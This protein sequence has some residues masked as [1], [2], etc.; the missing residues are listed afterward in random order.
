[1]SSDGYFD[2]DLDDAAWAQ[3]DAI[4]AAYTVSTSGTQATAAKP[5]ASTSTSVPGP[6]IS[7]PKPKPL[8]SA[9][10]EDSFYDLTFD[11]DEDDFQQLDAIEQTYAGKTRPVGPTRQTTLFGDILPDNAQTNKPSSSRQPLQLTTS[12]PRNPFGSKPKKTKIWDQTAFAQSGQR[13][14]GKGKVGGDGVE[15]EE[16][17]PEF[18]QYPAPYVSPGESY[19]RFVSADHAQ[20]FRSIDE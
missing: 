3:L 13:K 4:E 12:T 15:K 8:D 7:K 5:V 19:S 2:D 17:P 6:S 14:K 10:K 9:P 11:L 1:M 16:P 20:Q 18:E